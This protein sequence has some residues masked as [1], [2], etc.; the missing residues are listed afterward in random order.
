MLY[1][2]A[3]P[4]P[5]YA[6]RKPRGG[7]WRCLAVAAV[8]ALFLYVTQRSSNVKTC[9]RLAATR[10][11]SHCGA[12]LGIDSP[13]VTEGRVEY[14]YS[15]GIAEFDMDL[16][17]STDGTMYVGHPRLL[18]EEFGVDPFELDDKRVRAGALTVERLL[19]MAA[20]DL[21]DLVLALDL[22]GSGVYPAYNAYLSRLRDMV[23]QRRLQHRAWI[24]VDDARTV[25]NLGPSQGVRF[26]RPLKDGGDPAADCA[27]QLEP[28]DARRFE[29]LG[30]SLT[31]ANHRFFESGAV[32]PW[33]SAPRH[34]LV[35][36]VDD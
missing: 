20:D 15:K 17:W 36:V 3:A 21:P 35:W 10:V 27:A 12:G 25:A 34:Y 16:F 14:L 8:V 30:P 2:P 22:K 11:F 28:A 29:F 9:R 32:A 5:S 13:V 7:P 26:G 23:E 31:C 24:W 19:D 33:R 4:R 18:K 6:R 1:S